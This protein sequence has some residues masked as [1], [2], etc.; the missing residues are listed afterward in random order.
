MFI[1]NIDR[2]RL[3]S[4]TR[5]RRIY[6][7]ACPPGIKLVLLQKANYILDTQAQA[8]VDEGLQTIVGR[9]LRESNHLSLTNDLVKLALSKVVCLKLLKLDL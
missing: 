5:I 1:L 8:F 9:F 7:D 4:H 3:G 2:N 6:E